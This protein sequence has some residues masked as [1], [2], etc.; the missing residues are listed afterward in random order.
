MWSTGFL[1]LSLQIWI[2]LLFLDTL[3]ITYLKEVQMSSCRTTD[4]G[5]SY[6]AETMIINASLFVFCSVVLSG[7]MIPGHPRRIAEFA[8]T[9]IPPAVTE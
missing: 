3:Q 7:W 9:L 8:N 4:L 2:A 5:V 6:L 1:L